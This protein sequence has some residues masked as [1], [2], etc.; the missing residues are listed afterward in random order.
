M[1][2]EHSAWCLDARR[3]RVRIDDLSMRR[4]WIRSL[5]LVAFLGRVALP[6]FHFHEHEE[7]GR[8]GEC[9][10]H[11]RHAPDREAA[12]PSV[13]HAE[14]ACA[15]CELLA[16]QAPGLVPEPP[17]EATPERPAFFAP[18]WE[19]LAAPHAASFF[20]VGAPRGPPP[21]SSFA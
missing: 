8:G 9:P 16:T 10:H 12:G 4:L 2:G 17:P 14:H 3:D 11:H 5:V 7:G 20:V 13:A 15:I 6:A 18:A 1:V 19:A 21:S